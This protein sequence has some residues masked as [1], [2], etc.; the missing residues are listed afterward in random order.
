MKRTALLAAIAILS[1]GTPALGGSQVSEFCQDGVS[2]LIDNCIE[3]CNT[4]QDDTDQDD[5]GNLCDADYDNSGVVGFADFGAFVAGFGGTNE[6][7]CHVEPISGC[8][9]GFGD[10]GFMVSRFGSIPGPS[11]TTA[12]TTACP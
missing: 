3:D 10:F 8:T 11:G 1:W 7:Y 12:G 6:V 9:V 4:N 2:Y 5:C